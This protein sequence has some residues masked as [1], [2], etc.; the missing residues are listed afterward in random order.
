MRRV[1]FGLLALGFAHDALAGEFGLPIL[2]GSNGYAAPTTRWSG[3]YLGAQAGATVSSVDFGN[4]TKSLVAFMLRNT[5]L[6]NEAGVSNWTTLGKDDGVSRHVGGFVGYNTQWDEV[7]LGFELNYN[8]TAKTLSASDTISRSY[9]ASDDYDYAVDITGTSSVHITDYGTARLRAGWAVG[10]ILPY[11]M[12][13]LAVGRA[14]VSRTATV[15][16]VGT[17]VGSSGLPNTSLSESMSEGKNGAFA[18]GYAVGLG[19]DM[20]LLDNVFVRGEWEYVTFANFNDL[21]VN[22]NSARVAAGV[23]F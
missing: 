7:V 16:V 14:N 9:T 19:V 21:K 4:A 5:T 1:I 17:Y 10:S 18:Y 8:R 3:V 15:N 2:R 12:V 22:I 6:E 13:G 23:K 20:A 11:A